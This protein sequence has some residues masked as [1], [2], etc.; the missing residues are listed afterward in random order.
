MKR[1]AEA[2]PI[3]TRVL[4]IINATATNWTGITLG[5][6]RSSISVLEELHCASCGGGR[7]GSQQPALKNVQRH[8]ERLRG[9]VRAGEDGYNHLGFPLWE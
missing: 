6:P 1:S 4:L 3:I 5:H 7:N 9:A 8:N 2:V